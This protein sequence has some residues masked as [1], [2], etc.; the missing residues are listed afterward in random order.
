MPPSSS[1]SPTC[2]V[3]FVSLVTTALIVEHARQ[4]G[5]VEGGGAVRLGPVSD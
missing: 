3:S 4:D 2:V 1:V 5:K